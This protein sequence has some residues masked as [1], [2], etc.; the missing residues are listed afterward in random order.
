MTV[1]VEDRRLKRPDGPAELRRVCTDVAKIGMSPEVGGGVATE[2]LFGEDV[3]CFSVADGFTQ[4]RCMRDGYVGWM[5]SEHLA[6]P[7]SELSHRVTALRT[8]AYAEANLKSAAG[9]A[10]SFGSQ[11]CV[12]RT[13]GDY[14]E[15]NGAGWVH[16]AHL[17]PLS[18]PFSDDPARIAEQYVHTPY[19]WGG[20]SGLGLDCSGLVQQAFEAAGVMIPRDSDMQ[21]AWAG[22]NIPDWTA[23]GALQ[24]GDLVFWDGHVGI[25]LAPDTLLH[26]NAS[27]MAVAAEPLAEAIE[28]I[29]SKYAAPI[30]ARRIDLDTSRGE[31]PDWLA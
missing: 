17:Q 23:P 8:F 14:A 30:G 5:P 27:H 15:C 9:V 20:R 19:L 16:T 18:A 2:A 11:V 13:D 28:R 4:V 22:D 26:A 12:T 29:K 10:L 24:R 3:E 25:M 1:T 6:T 7:G 31:T 21:F